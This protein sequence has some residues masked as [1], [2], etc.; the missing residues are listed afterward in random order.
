V[1]HIQLGDLSSWLLI[2]VTGVGVWA[3]IQA[4]KYAKKVYNSEVGRERARE[5]QEIRSQ[6]MLISGWALLK[7]DHHTVDMPFTLAAKVL[8]GSHQPIYD[9]DLR[10]FV[11]G[12]EVGA[13]DVKYNL[14]PPLLDH[15]WPVSRA[16]YLAMGS[17]GVSPIV[18]YDGAREIVGKSRLSI[19][20]SDAEGRRWTREPTGHL[21]M[22]AE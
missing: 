17:E 21:N 19:T 15:V 7:T 4:G 18:T 12:A 16:S 1:A 22:V 6:A 13:L 9:V 5:D 20:F 8:N 10:W 11:E 14:I 3:A 2:V